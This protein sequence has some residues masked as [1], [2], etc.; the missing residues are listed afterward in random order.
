ERPHLAPGGE[1]I[2]RA[3]GR[4][5]L[6]VWQIQYREVER[7]VGQ[8]R[9]AL[10]N[11]ADLEHEALA[12]QRARDARPLDAVAER[13]EESLL[14]TARSVAKH[15]QRKAGAIFICHRAT[16]LYP[17]IPARRRRSRVLTRWSIP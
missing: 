2:A 4:L 13:H 8:A 7:L 6:G 10:G 9:Q 16:R 11:R 5:Q 12:V 1:G 17:E 14:P 3:R 15:L